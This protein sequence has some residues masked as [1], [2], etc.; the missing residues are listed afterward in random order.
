MNRIT[1][2]TFAQKQ[3]FGSKFGISPALTGQYFIFSALCPSKSGLTNKHI[4]KHTD[5]WNSRCKH[6][7]IEHVRPNKVTSKAQKR[8]PTVETRHTPLHPEAFVSIE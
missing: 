6:R 7:M 8:R 3:V 1:G 4:V 5:L 2:A